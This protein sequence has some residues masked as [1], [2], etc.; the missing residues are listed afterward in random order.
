VGR[1]LTELAD[2]LERAAAEVAASSDGGAGVVAGG[3][4]GLAAGLCEAVSRASLDSWPDAR[5]AAAQGAELRRRAGLATAENAAAYAAARAM[6]ARMP[7]GTGR[8]ATL[9]AAL[10]RAADAP[11][12]IATIALDCATLAAAIAESGEAALRADAAAAAELAAAT[13]RSAAGLVEINLA[14]LPGDAR[15]QQARAVA[16]AADEQRARARAA[17]DTA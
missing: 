4:A 12:S 10:V 8:D 17:L 9:R 13:A 11:L 5:G 3:V 15:R 7:A 2:A 1:A 14:L 16:G 6:L